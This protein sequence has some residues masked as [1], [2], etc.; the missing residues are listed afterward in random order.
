MIVHFIT[1]LSVIA[2]LCVCVCA[3]MHVCVYMC[4]CVRERTVNTYFIMEYCYIR[5]F[6]IIVLVELL[7]CKDCTQKSMKVDTSS[8][9]SI[10]YY[11][12]HRL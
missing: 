11:N 3:C 4:V 8:E 2:V 10:N 9:V 12:I 6:F 7:N 1:I 5:I